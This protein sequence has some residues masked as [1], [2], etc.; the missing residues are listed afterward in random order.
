T[1]IRVC[2]PP[3]RGSLA[4]RCVRTMGGGAKARDG[5]LSLDT[6]SVAAALAS[7]RVVRG[8]S[9]SVASGGGARSFTGGATNGR[10]TFGGATATTLGRG[11][12]L[13]ALD[14]GSGTQISEAGRG[15]SRAPATI[16]CGAVTCARA[17]RA[18]IG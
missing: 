4:C 18:E 10:T 3:A 17:G 12:S 14:S 5:A 16:V 11:V 8:A 15:L 13:G 2:G 6:G 7:G 1:T 9:G